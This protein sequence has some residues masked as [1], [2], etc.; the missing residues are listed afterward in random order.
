MLA[1]PIFAAHARR[2]EQSCN[3]GWLLVIS[4]ILTESEIKFF[5]PRISRRQEHLLLD[6]RGAAK[7]I[8]TGGQNFV[9]KCIKN[10]QNLAGR[11][12]N[13][14]SK[15]KTQYSIDYTSISLKNDWS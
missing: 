3:D 4:A 1:R 14:T 12:Y 15:T 13:L 5:L 8:I 9:K 11:N 10:K 6:H 7:K 2:T